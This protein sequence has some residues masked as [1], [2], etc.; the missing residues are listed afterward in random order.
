[1]D[2]TSNSVAVVKNLRG[3]F[4]G[5]NGAV[6]KV[7]KSIKGVGEWMDKLVNKGSEI[8]KMSDGVGV[9]SKMLSNAV[10]PSMNLTSSLTNLSIVADTVGNKLKEIDGFASNTTVSFQTFSGAN[11]N[12]AS[13]VASSTNQMN[14]YTN[15]VINSNMS[16]MQ[17]NVVMNV[18]STTQSEMQASTAESKMGLFDI[19]GG[20]IDFA[21][22]VSNTIKKLRDIRDTFML[23]KDEVVGLYT[24]MKD[25]G[26]IER[27]R[28]VFS[29]QMMFLKAD[30]Q[31][32]STWAINFGKSIGRAGMAIIRF[33]TVGIFNALKGMGAFILSLVTGGATSAGFASISSASFSA[34]GVSFKAMCTSFTAAVTQ[35]PIYGWIIGFIALLIG[36]GIY[37]WNT[38]ATFKATLIGIWEAVKAVF[39][40][41]GS[42]VSEV[43]S[44]L[45]DL[46]KG[47]FNPA[48]WFDDNYS[49]GDSLGKIADA[50]TK[51]GNSIG[52]AFNKG[53]EESMAQSIAEEELKTEQDAADEKG[54]SLQ[55]Y[56]KAKSK[57]AEENISV[58]EYLEKKPGGMDMTKMFGGDPA[59]LNMMAMPQ[60][61]IAGAINGIGDGGGGGGSDSKIKNITTTIGSLIGGNI[62]INATTVTEGAGRMKDIVM[63][64]LVS[65]VNDFSNAVN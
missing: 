35:I 17:A 18:Y 13:A 34:T 32:A 11:A 29:Y 53:K 40:G 15:A 38:S 31:S 12:I 46:I 39:G 41:I 37:F 16:M 10:Q 9:F 19:I 8:G 56:Q 7:Q 14:M 43:L 59:A 62:V 47:V 33:A 49:F 28:T 5:L 45:W 63:Q 23:V 42:F 30:L 21:S 25:T 50:A 2:L 24:K 64:E 65:A 4:D 54:M 36:L 48:N 51:Y 57:A 22:T 1:M 61:P 6:I 20:F 44:G 58:D 60:S 55:D 3:E 27:M 52:E 26:T